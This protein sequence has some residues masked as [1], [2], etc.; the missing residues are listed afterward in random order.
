MMLA[1]A[2]VALKDNDTEKARDLASRV[3]HMGVT[4]DKPGDDS[5]SAI[6]REIAVVALAHQNAP[7]KPLPVAPVAVATNSVPPT[8]SP[9][10]LAKVR[11]RELLAE[12]RKYQSE[13]KLVEA[14]EKVSEAQKA[15]GSFSSEEDT[16]ALAAQQLALLGRKQQRRSCSNWRMRC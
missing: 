3:D 9:V 8:P 7:T 1:E 6:Y 16:P 2:R 11:A 5:P 10:E 4:L 14:M 12:G 15:G 13:G